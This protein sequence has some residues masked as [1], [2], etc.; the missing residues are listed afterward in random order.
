MVDLEPFKEGLPR[1]YAEEEDWADCDRQV[2]AGMEHFIPIS[3][4]NNVILVR[5][6]IKGAGSGYFILDTGASSSSVSKVLTPNVNLGD[7]GRSLMFHGAGGDVAGLYRAYPF[8][9]QFGSRWYAKPALIAQDLQAISNREGIEISGLIGCP[10]LSRSR[11]SIDYRDGLL[12]LEE[13]QDRQ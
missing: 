10:E 6:E 11:V 12:N 8:A 7:F 9:L 4:I 1:L 13:E 2:P 5:T 3:Q